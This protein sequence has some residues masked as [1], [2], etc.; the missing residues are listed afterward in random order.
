M[1]FS[2][3]VRDMV[4]RKL[5]RF[6]LRIAGVSLSGEKIWANLE[7]SGVGT[8]NGARVAEVLYDIFDVDQVVLEG[9]L[10]QKA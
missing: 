10:Y 8:Y 5:Q 3:T 7:S 6:G 4:N 2:A 1:A 9:Q